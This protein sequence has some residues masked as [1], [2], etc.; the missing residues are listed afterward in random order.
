MLSLFQQL[1]LSQ[2]VQSRNTTSE[3]WTTLREECIQVKEIFTDEITLALLKYLTSYSGVRT[4][5]INSVSHD[6]NRTRCIQFREVRDE[7]L[8]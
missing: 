6:G 4:T 3:I 8:Q 5:E 7:V 1:T 2:I